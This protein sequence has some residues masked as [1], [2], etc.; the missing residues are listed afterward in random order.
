MCNPDEAA[1]AMIRSRPTPVRQLPSALLMLILAAGVPAS[2]TTVS[3]PLQP[4]S[5]PADVTTSGRFGPQGPAGPDG[6]QT[7]LVP[8]QISGL[9][10]WASLV[11]PP[12]NRPV[13]LVIIA[14]GSEQD[15]NA[16]ALAPQAD[17]P[18]LRTFLV[19][20]G[21]AVLIPER[22][23]HGRTGGPYLEDQGPCAAPDYVRSANAVADSLVAAIAY[24]KTQTAIVKGPVIVVGNSAGGLGALALAARNPQGID[25]IINFAGGRGGHDNNRPNRNCAP[26]ALVAAAATFGKTSRIPTLW[27]Y[28]ENDTW[29]PPD[30]SR[31][32]ADAF[33]AAGGN[34]TYRLLP[35]IAGD[36]HALAFAPSSTWAE[37]LAAFLNPAN[38]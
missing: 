37:D 14:H 12:G 3:Q 21:Y 4:G 1:A 23:G 13:P 30:L 28:A 25:R 7:W 6:R 24:M 10:A 5:Q 20:R 32:M 38:R 11:V 34:A 33:I 19:G 26:D 15:A 36:G 29:F 22:P 18:E 16:R 9:S 27:L 2:C 17:F 35:P 8:T 31:K